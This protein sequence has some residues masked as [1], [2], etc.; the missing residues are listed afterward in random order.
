MLMVQPQ[1]P[2]GALRQQ[3]PALER[4]TVCRSSKLACLLLRK[5]DDDLEL[6][7]PPCGFALHLAQAA[8]P[9][10]IGG[11]LLERA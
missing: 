11:I 3:R 9:L 2:L 4:A 5:R 1:K 10:P 7:D 8:R 6:G